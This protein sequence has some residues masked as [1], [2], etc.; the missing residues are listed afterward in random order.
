MGRAFWVCRWCGEVEPLPGAGCLAFQNSQGLWSLDRIFKTGA[1]PK[2]PGQC[3]AGV[4]VLA[5]WGGVGAGKIEASFCIFLCFW[6]L[7][8]PN[9]MPHL[10]LRLS[11]PQSLIHSSNVDYTTFLYQVPWWAPGTS[12]D[13]RA[14]INTERRP[15]FFFLRYICISNIKM[16]FSN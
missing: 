5:S 8:L 2:T 4:R 14:S 1:A 10:E 6:P 9:S 12:G 7:S 11:L 16:H 13:L 3:V 15:F